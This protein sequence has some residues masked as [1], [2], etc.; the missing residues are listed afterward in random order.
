VVRPV[1]I[2]PE[3]VRVGECYLTARGVV[4]RVEALLPNGWVVYHQRWGPVP[5]G[6]PWPRHDEVDPVLFAAAVE[7]PVLCDWTPKGEV[8]EAGD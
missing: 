2:P 3:S 5:E 6:Y 8:R 4:R 7:S 1:S